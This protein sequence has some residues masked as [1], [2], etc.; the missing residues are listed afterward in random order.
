MDLDGRE[1]RYERDPVG[2][3]TAQVNGAGERVSYRRD[4]L[5]QVICRDHDGLTDAFGYDPMGRLLRASTPDTE[6]GFAYDP[7]GRVLTETVDGRAQ[8]STYDAAGRRVRRETASGAVSDWTFDE[9]SQPLGLVAGPG[10]LE[11]GHDAGGRESSMRLGEVLLTRTFDADG[12]LHAQRVSAGHRR[13]VD[14]V[15]RYRGDGSLTGIDDPLAGSVTFD[16]D[17]VGRITAASSGGSVG[18]F[19]YD[20]AGR[21]LAGG[22]SSYEGTRIRGVG[23]AGAGQHG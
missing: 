12:R 22:R 19:A 16:L 21:P 17:P 23:R 3:L 10:R 6:V 4:A 14:R 20:V 8:T 18:R 2:R 1:L 7:A 11:F 5:G 13:L 9:A 15:H